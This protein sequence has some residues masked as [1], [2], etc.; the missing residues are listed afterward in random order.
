MSDLE[1]A[2]CAEYSTFPKFFKAATAQEG[3]H[4]GYLPYPYQEKLAEGDM[5]NMLKLPTG[6]GKTEAAIISLWLWRRFGPKQSIRAATPRRL[7]YCLPMRSL[8]IQ[9]AERARR[10]VS[11]LKLNISVITMM[12]SLQ[13]E[14]YR[15]RPHQDA[16]IVGTQDMLLSR[17]LNRGYALEPK[18]WPTEFGILN[19]DCFWIMDEIQIMGVG[20]PTSVQLEAFRNKFHTYGPHK[21]VW[22]SAT[23]D[24]KWLHTV[25]GEKY[26]VIK[27][28]EPY[29]LGESDLDRK[30]GI[31]QIINAPK[32]LRILDGVVS[33]DV[34]YDDSSSKKIYGRHVKG[35]MTIV[36]LNTVDRARELYGSLRRI[37][38]NDDV[39]PEIIL[40][41]SRFRHKDKESILDKIKERHAENGRVLISTQ[42]VEAGMDI[43]SQTLIT[44]VA[45]WSSMVQRFGRC[46]RKGG[47][48]NAAVWVIKPERSDN[49][50]PYR[51]DDIDESLRNINKLANG[52]VQPTNLQ[53][54]PLTRKFFEDVIRIPYMYDL[55]DTTADLYGGHTDIARYVRN[56]EDATDVQVLWRSWAGDEPPDHIRPSNAT[57]A[58]S[59]PSLRKFASGAN[60]KLYRRDG[61]KKTWSCVHKNDVVPGQTILVH[62]DCGGY[63]PTVGWQP[64][65]IERVPEIIEG[66]N[67]AAQRSG[68]KPVTLIDHTVHVY[69]ELV[70][71]LEG[72]GRLKRDEC[73]CLKTAAILHDSGKAHDIFQKAVRKATPNMSETDEN[74]SPILLAKSGGSGGLNYGRPDFRHEAFSAIAYLTYAKN[75][76]ENMHHLTAYLIMSHHGKVRMQIRNSPRAYR[77]GRRPNVGDCVAGLPLKRDDQ[78][79]NFLR[80]GGEFLKT[81]GMADG[82]FGNNDKFAVNGSIARLGRI[83]QTGTGTNRHVVKSWGEISHGLL[84]SYG[85]FRLAYMESVLRAADST[86]SELENRR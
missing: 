11:N 65:S 37:T 82:W 26:G 44:E 78:F 59:L 43:T 31:A 25:D 13:Y 69:E 20:L 45:P 10:F 36:I 3:R 73:E 51:G 1:P 27:D 53:H 15:T 81:E 21:T 23:L 35:S 47:D 41:H 16:I 29:E 48:E 33:T 12:G 54:I 67:S 56:A 71:I 70:A 32:T 61:W 86:A 52:S 60:R 9:T 22:M 80:H 83:K 84:Q 42:V 30:Y 39:V 68:S 49:S 14:K 19:N 57:C 79:D 34:A 17:A 55:F 50:P 74:K 28:Q 24:S 5:P 76:R 77:M 64:D 46:N 72:E 2:L 62:C 38:K 6:T 40:L 58:V 4:G 18:M 7:V 85:P 66:P 75:E 63:T 8:V